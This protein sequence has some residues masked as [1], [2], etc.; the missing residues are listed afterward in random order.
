[1]DNEKYKEILQRRIKAVDKELF[2]GNAKALGVIAAAVDALLYIEDSDK[3]DKDDVEYN[4]YKI[5]T[6]N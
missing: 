5:V 3:F 4:K 2:D 1:M 6:D